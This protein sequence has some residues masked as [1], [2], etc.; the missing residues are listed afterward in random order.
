MHTLKLKLAI[1]LIQDSLS[2]EFWHFSLIHYL[3]IVIIIIISHSA[4]AV[5]I[6]DTEK[7]F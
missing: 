4:R 5:F 1:V 6:S 3:Q 2:D 7:F